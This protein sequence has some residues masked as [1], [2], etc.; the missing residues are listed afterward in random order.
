MKKIILLVLLLT[1]A[2]SA[3]EVVNGNRYYVAG[4]GNAIQVPNAASTGTTVNKLAKLTG[5]GTA[6]ITAT[7][8][9]SGVIGVVI[10][11]AGTTGNAAIVRDG[12]ASLVFDG[13]TTANDYISISS[14]VTGDGTDAGAT[15]PGSGQ[16]I[17]RVLSTHGSGGTYAIIVGSS[18]CGGG[19]GG[20]GTVTS[21]GL[22]QTGSLFTITGTPITT[23]GNI[24]INFTGLLPVANGGTGASSPSLVAGSNVT[25]TG[26][27]PNQTVASTGGGGTVNNALQN[28]FS[29][30]S[31]A[32]TTNTID[33]L[34]GSTGPDGV[35][36]VP[37][38]ISTG[39]VA[40][41][42]Q[43]ALPGISGR[44]VTGTTSTDTITSADCV[45]N[46]IAYIGSV[47][48]AITLPTATTL[49]VP[50]CV[51]KV[52]NGTSG[53]STTLTITP[54]TW[55]ISKGGGS[56]GATLVIAQGQE[57][58]IYVDANSATNWVAD[59]VEQGLSAG[60]NITFTRSNSGLSIASSGGGSSA[61]P[62]T[63]SGTVTSGGI[64]Y[65]SNTTTESSSALLANNGIVIGGGAGQPPNTTA[66]LTTD[67][68]SKIT[69][70]T[71]NST[72]GSVQMANASAAAHTIWGSGA[73]TTN[74]I[75]GFTVA[76]TTG[77]MV[78]CTTSGTTC[79]LT[80]GGA[81]S[82]SGTVTSIATTSPITGGTIT[83]TGTIA[84]ATCTTN[85]S[86]LTSNMPVIG[87]G[88][89][90]AAVGTVSGN[91]TEFATVT[92]SLTSGNLTKSDASG[93]VVDA[94]FPSVST[95][96]NLYTEVT[97]SGT[98]TNA[99]SS[100]ATNMFTG[101]TIPA[102]TLTAG[103]RIQATACFKH[104]T[105][106]TGTTYNW[107]IGG[108]AAVAVVSAS[109]ASGPFCTT[110]YLTAI[111]STHQSSIDTISVGSAVAPNQAATT[112]TLTSSNTINVTQAAAGTTDVYTAYLLT[113][114]LW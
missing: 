107:N 75:L 55:T 35:P 21:A 98:T 54:T 91:T 80:D 48:V 94:G 52:I 29:Y 77:H 20:S 69:L 74:T 101:F 61:F 17:G 57:A 96:H 93:N 45:P 16:V 51:F 38:S 12:E 62:L 8:D 47:S 49:A 27:W 95:G 85:A 88:S 72:A 37:V 87:A 86:A 6:V 78:T 109:T 113:V 50:Q 41:T 81:P 111:D 108:S 60:S 68:T 92:G 11:G 36:Q 99:A 46:R 114:D 67:G 15:C 42:P 104:S 9:T 30:Y 64:P 100:V 84:C 102:N 39:G 3:Q 28:S 40:G 112:F 2:A 13:A 14:S 89:Q 59:V 82:G 19:G 31:G 58:V 53:S 1:L 83:T 106:S 34:N 103:H 97:S 66:G 33:G 23:A 5:A 25:I 43:L 79:T 26:T 7:T 65:F 24:N 73:T 56:T 90:A 32:G 71:D 22:T 70:G 105:G 4:T 76:P 44:V 63:V 10:G 110:L 18:G